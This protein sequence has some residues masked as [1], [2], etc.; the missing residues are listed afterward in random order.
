MDP[1]THLF[2]PLLFLFS[3]GVVNDKRREKLALL[4]SPV[5]VMPD[6]DILI[7][8]RGVLHVPL[9]VLFFSVVSFLL[10]RRY[11]RVFAALLFSLYWWSHLF[12][13]FIAGGIPLL[14]PLSNMC[15]GVSIA[16]KV[17]FSSGSLPSRVS[18]V[19]PRV[20]VVKHV[21]FNTTHGVFPIATSF[22][23]SCAVFFLLTL[24]IRYCL[25]YTSPSP[26]DRTRSRMPSS[27]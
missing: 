18:V 14:Y 5:A 23:V 26:R 2:L 13:D 24:L 11:K 4:L 21:G 12:L 22:G 19:P 25:L 6:I 17:S 7:G 27:A 3:T 15:F 20:N 10:A 8:H 1:V 16:F 9:L